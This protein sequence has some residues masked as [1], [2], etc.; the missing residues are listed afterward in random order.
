MS[1][2]IIS[3]RE[4]VREKIYRTRRIGWASIFFGIENWKLQVTLTMHTG[5]DI[6]QDG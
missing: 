4:R 3:L 5:G 1:P 6:Q 2:V